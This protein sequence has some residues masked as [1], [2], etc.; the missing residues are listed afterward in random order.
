MSHHE[1]N[2]TF[3]TSNQDLMGLSDSIGFLS[4][5][6]VDRLRSPQSRQNDIPE[7]R[8]KIYRS[9]KNILLD[10]LLEHL[11]TINTRIEPIDFFTAR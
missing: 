9:P 2:I 4:Y 3:I 7:K 8:I 11:S 1:R 6:D 10:I 5:D